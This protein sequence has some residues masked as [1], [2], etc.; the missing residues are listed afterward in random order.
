[1]DRSQLIHKA[2]EMTKRSYS[3][4]SHFT[5][6]AAILTKNG[7]IYTGCNIENAA[8]PA[9]ICAEQVAITNA[10]SDG[11]REFSEIAI[12]GGLEGKIADFCP[13]CGICR[14]VMMEFVNPKEF[15]V[16]LAKSKEEYKVYSLEELLPFGFG[17]GNL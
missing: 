16:I 9:T 1:M 11:E 7:K 17:P 10:V 3:P 14:Q 8:Y 15:H 5:V 4:Y 2:I 12:V 13:P 6:G